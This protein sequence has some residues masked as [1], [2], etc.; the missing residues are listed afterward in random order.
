[1][2]KNYLR[3]G[4]NM[5]N[6]GLVLV[7]FMFTSNS[8]T[9]QPY[10][11]DCFT[12]N[13][14]PGC[15]DGDCNDLICGIDPFCCDI[16]WDGLCAGQA[17]DLCEQE[18]P[19]YDGDCFSPNGTPGC[20]DANCSD[21]ICGMDPFCCDI[22]WDALCVSQAE[23]YCVPP[24]ACITTQGEPGDLTDAGCA[25]FK[26]VVNESGIIG[27]D[28]SLENVYTMIMHS[29]VGDLDATLTSPGGVSVDLFDRPGFP[30]L[31]FG[32]SGDDIDVEF[33][34]GAA[35]TSGDFEG[36]CSNLP[37]ISGDYQPLVPFSSFNGQEASGMWVLEICD[38]VGGDTGGLKEFS[39]TFCGGDS[40]CDDLAE[41][42][43]L[44]PCPGLIVLCGA[45]NVSW[46]PPTATDNCVD[47][48]V[49]GS[50]SPGDFF[51]VGLT[52]VTYTATDG[53]GNTDDC[54]FDILINPLP[55]LTIDQSDLPPFCQ[56]VKILYANVSNLADLAPPVSYS[57]SNDLGSN[58][59]VQ[60]NE[61]GVYSVTVVDGNGCSSVASTLVD[62]DY[63]ELLSAHT[64]IVDDEMDM[65]E[66]TV[67]SGGVGVL[68]ADEISITDNSN[69]T[70]FLRSS[71]AEIDGSSNVAL[72]INSDSPLDLPDF[73][74]NPYADLNNVNVLGVT[75]LSGSNYGSVV[76]GTGATLN[77]ANDQIYFRSLTVRKGGTVNFLQPTSLMVRKKIHIGSSCNIN[78]EGPFVV[79]YS[80]D[81]VSVGEGSSVWV[82]IYA[83]EG[84]DVNES[85][86]SLTTYM[87]G[88]FISDELNSGD[89]VVWGWNTV[90]GE[91]IDNCN[92]LGAVQAL[93][94]VTK[95]VTGFCSTDPPVANTCDCPPGYVVVGY[96][97]EKGNS[98]G[99]NVIS[100]FSLRCKKLNGNGT[101]GNTVIVTC[102][103]GS[104]SGIPD[105][106]VDAAANHVMVGAGL[107]IGCAVDQVRGYSKPISDVIAGSPNLM[108]SA[109]P[110]IGG[111][112]GG[113]QPNQY[114]PNGHVIVGMVTYEETN[115]PGGFN[116]LGASAGVAWRYAPVALCDDNDPMS[117]AV[118]QPEALETPMDKNSGLVVFPNPS[119]G[120]MDVGVGDYLGS[121]V[122]VI[123][124]NV[125]GQQVWF[126]SIDE[127]ETSKLTIDL[128]ADRYPSGIYN[129]T[130]LV[131]DA[132]ITK[133]IVLSK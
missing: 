19:S 59:G 44:S 118:G 92:P 123:I 56:G 78:V 125:M 74:S 111:F 80:G 26:L 34:D 13:G 36:A 27:V 39:M 99:P 72:H 76:V 70:T 49:V 84:L 103:N 98:Y 117:A 95:A 9:A 53:A 66:S 120:M 52:T 65:S 2:K 131:N 112:G 60:V 4:L 25:Q 97:G 11:G 105:G 38:N 10:D 114:A 69:I 35:N 17:L 127:L 93:P 102:S 116:V 83:P 55:D 21:L 22:E 107:N 51:G 12:A 24:P 91:N 73:I 129:M 40:N 16:S 7:L 20:E 6:T 96:E 87:Y 71:A 31:F 94:A 86:A 108:S 100:N 58:S 1:M 29:W 122:D 82:N 48:T 23:V 28:V 113:A 90:C 47:P 18:P 32:C 46:T 132:I 130:L 101:L 54:S 110:I 63:S 62:E 109:M 30:D 33:S 37:A 104:L 64:I 124:T 41:G 106:P 43:E 61:N 88:M 119:S 121:S 89:D 5:I 8:V 115:P 128:T 67:L 75:T 133:Q 15:E 81:N 14:T 126:Q 57:W 77:I 68:D 50:A 42:P 45:Q 3:F 79:V 85:P